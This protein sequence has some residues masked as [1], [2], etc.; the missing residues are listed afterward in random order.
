MNRRNFLER[1]TL[2]AS[3]LVLAPSLPAKSQDVFPSLCNLHDRIKD[4][5]IIES[6]TLLKAEGELFV[7]VKGSNGLMGIT[8]GNLR[9]PNLVSIFQ[10]MVAPF[11]KGKDARDI[12]Q[13]VADVYTDGRNYKY[14]GMPFSNCVG[15]LEIAIMDLLGKTANEPVRNFFGPTLRTKLDVY[16]SSLTRE[17]TPEEEADFLKSK[18]EE[19]GAK[20]VKI[21]VGGRMRYDDESRKRTVKLVPH[22]RKALGD[23]ITIYADGNSSFDVAN[24]IEVGKM[25]QDNGVT[26]FE[27]PCPWE[28]VESTQKVTKALKIK[29]AGGEQDTS[30]YRWNFIAKNSVYDLLQP[31]VFY[32]GGITRL[33]EVASIANRYGKQIAP[34]SPKADSLAAPFMQAVAVLP[35][36]YGY[37]EYPSSAVG[38]KLPDWFQP[39]IVIKNGSM[40]IPTG[41]GLGISFDPDFWKKADIVTC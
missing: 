14:A 25:L 8:M 11:F 38:K 5:V 34:H 26:V 19:T 32:N 13:L 40:G 15:T 2:A 12:G 29:V 3:A 21:K 24:G 20:A 6:I 18:L 37:Q 30:L 22:I 39:H 23:D 1:T 4:P 7:H 27:E 33:I 9:L 41:P 28:D 31:D 36:L 16:L 10:N 17:T 35:N